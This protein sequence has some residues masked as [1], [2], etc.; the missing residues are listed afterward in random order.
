MIKLLIILKA[1]KVFRR[2]IKLASDVFIGQNCSDLAAFLVF[3][4]IIQPSD[5]LFKALNSL[6]FGEELEIFLVK[7]LFCV[8]TNKAGCFFDV[9]NVTG[10][11]CEISKFLL[12]LKLKR[13]YVFIIKQSKLRSFRSISTISAVSTS[14]VLMHSACPLEL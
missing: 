12:N 8:R 5:L 13:I 7:A 1:S 14:S 6:A 11:D 10:C 4:I 2:S 9:I 3:T